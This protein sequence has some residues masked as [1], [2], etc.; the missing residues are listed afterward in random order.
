MC[1][2]ALALFIPGSGLHAGTTGKI[3]GRV[4]DAQTG[5][6][7]APTAVLYFITHSFTPKL[8]VPNPVEIRHLQAGCNIH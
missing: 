3:K 8:L 4:V 7:Y 1:S 5:E 2:F 6:G